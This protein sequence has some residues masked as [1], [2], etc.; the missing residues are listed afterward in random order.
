ME[1]SNTVSI[2]LYNVNNDPVAGNDTVSMDTLRDADGEVSGSV[3]LSDADGDSVGLSAVTGPNGT[4]AWGED[5]NDDAAY[6]V[7]GNY[8]VLYVYPPVAGEAVRYRY[9]LTDATAA[10]IDDSEVFTYTADDGY[11]GT[12][13]GVITVNLTN[14]NAAPVVTG[15]VSLD[16]DTYRAE[17]GKIEGGISFGDTD[18]NTDEGRY[19]TASLSGVGFGTVQ[20]ASDGAGGFVVDGEYGSFHIL[21]DGTYTY[22]LDPDAVGVAET[23]TFTV[24]V[25]DE[26]GLTSTRDVDVN[27][28]SDNEAPTVD[29]VD[30]DFERTSAIPTRAIRPASQG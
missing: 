24:A 19:D 28:L 17:G 7:E 26:P 22:T 11:L 16:L 6:V 5:E 29:A 30:V 20:G 25:T 8:G 18:Y 23:E 21:A 27:L 15:D 12:D 1:T 10:G 4:G 2:E 9:V 3:D 14:T 13:T